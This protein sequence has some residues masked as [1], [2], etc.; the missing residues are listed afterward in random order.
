MGHTVTSD[1]DCLNKIQS[2]IM[3]IIFN[4][5]RSDD[6]WRHANGNISSVANLYNS[7][8]KKLCMKHH[9][10][11]LPHHFSTTIMPDFNINQLENKIS[12]ISLSHM[13]D[14]KNSSKSSI[15]DMKSNCISHWNSLSMTLKSLPYISANNLYK[16]LKK[17]NS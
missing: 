6:A 10:G 16:H 9:C 12:R 1:Q 2:K 4:C 8:I 5:K 15:S 13:Y 17:L 14:Y 7:V 11:K 3:R